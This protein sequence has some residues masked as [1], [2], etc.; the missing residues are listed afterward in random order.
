MKI[1]IASSNPVKTQ[2]AAAGFAR[3]FPGQALELSSASVPSGVSTQPLSDAETLRGALQRAQA[4]A[5]LRP[6]ANFWVGIEGGVEPF[7][8]DLAAFAWAVVGSRDRLGRGRTGAFLLPGRVAELVR[9]G[10]EVGEADDIVF[11]RSNSKQEN[12]AVGLLTGDVIDR[13][14]LYQ[15][16]VILALI[17]FKNPELYPP[18]PWLD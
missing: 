9:A 16:A 6:A 13:T 1:V 17:P 15:T 7:G 4:A 10:K 14:A 2:A 18:A 3:M 8:P 11:Q 5:R 12:G